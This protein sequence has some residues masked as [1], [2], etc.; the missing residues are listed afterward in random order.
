[1]GRPLFNYWSFKTPEDQEEKTGIGNTLVWMSHVAIHFFTD[2]R[3]KR[4]LNPVR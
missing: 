3:W 4:T 1:M 2:T